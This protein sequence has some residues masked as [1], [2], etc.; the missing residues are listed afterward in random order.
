MKFEPEQNVKIKM[1]NGDWVD[2]Q[3]VKK[4]KKFNLYWVKII[5]YPENLIRNVNELRLI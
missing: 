3:I 5:G 4:D 2:G 1:I